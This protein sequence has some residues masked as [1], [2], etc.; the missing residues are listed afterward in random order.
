M[1][2]VAQASP[3]HGLRR[4]TPPAWAGAAAGSMPRMVPV[5]VE[6]PGGLKIYSYGV[7]LGLSC[8]LGAHIAVYLAE[9]SRIERSRA[10]WFAVIVIAVGIVGGR[11]HDLIVNSAALE[12]WVAVQHAGRTAYGAFLAASVA[13]VV[14]ARALSVPFWRIADAVAPTMAIGLGLTRIGCFLYGCDYGVRSDGA[15]GVSFPRGSPAWTDQRD[16]GL[17]EFSDPASLPVLPVQL[18]ASALGLAIGGF[19]VWLWFRRPRR[20]GT[21]LLAFFLAYGL[22]R[23]GLE[24]IRG[25]LGRGELLGL[26]TSTTI[27]LATAT[28]AAAALFVPTLAS[29]RPEAGEVVPAGAPPDDADA[30]SKGASSKGAK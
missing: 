20:E 16:A 1:K 6:L 27:G 28:L 9:R 15:L 22:V 3:R 10:W 24:Q 21:V 29:L 4:P 14:A 2:E 5:L 12:E 30:S 18:L 8:V 7:M 11:I 25:D 23:A 13:G 17:L 26:S 19:L